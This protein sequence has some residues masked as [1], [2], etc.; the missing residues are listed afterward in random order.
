[1]GTAKQ[2]SSGFL[3]QGQLIRFAPHI[4]GG[5]IFILLVPFLPTYIQSLMTKILI[6]AIFA[7]SLDLLMGYAGV[8]SLG[9]AAYFG[10]AGYAVGILMVHY[11]INSF[12][13]SAPLAILL[14]T[15]VAAIFGIIVLQV[16]GIYCILVTFALGQLLYSIAM[17]WRSVTNGEYGLTGIIRPDLG[18]PHFTWHTTSFYYFVFI[19][20]AICFFLLYR[21]VKS[22]LGLALQGI[23]EGESRMS[24]LGYNTWLY[25]YIAF[26]I[27]GMFAGV[28]GVLFAY[29]NGIMVPPNLDVATSGFVMLMIIAGGMGT[30]YGSLIG[31]AVLIIIQFYAGVLTPE[32]WPLILGGAFVLTIMYARAGIGVYLYKLYKKALLAWKP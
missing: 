7:M 26:V 21:L 11:G 6:F 18:L 1:M 3:W 14:S 17:K 25:K 9:H 32:R 15:L 20:F 16:R 12:W 2:K 30:L 29:H 19:V 10:V 23:R 22:P 4:I 28:A 24:A 13:I 31:A 27:A 5:V 8:L